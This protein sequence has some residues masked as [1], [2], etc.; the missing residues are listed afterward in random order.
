[1]T[2]IHIIWAEF[3]LEEQHGNNEKGVKPLL[4][5]LMFTMSNFNL[6]VIKRAYYLSKVL[7]DVFLNKIL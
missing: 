4:V 1:M 3:L 7:T 2:P 5:S 6:V